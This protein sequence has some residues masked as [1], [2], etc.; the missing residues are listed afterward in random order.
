MLVRKTGMSFFLI[1]RQHS[2][3]AHGGCIGMPQKT[4][5]FKYC[6]DDPRIIEGIFCDHKI[7]FTQPWGMND[8]LEFNPTLQFPNNLAAH[9]GYSLNGIF[10][11]SIELFYRVQVIESQI[12]TYGILSLTTRHR[13]FDMWSR[14][15]NGHKG[16]VL[17][18]RQGFES[19]PCMMSKSDQ[20]NAFKAVEYVNTYSI[21]L[22]DFISGSKEFSWDVLHDEIFF[23]KTS[24][25]RD[26]HE[27]RLIRP[28]TDCSEYSPKSDRSHRDDS[29]Y[30]FDFSLECVTDVIFGASMSEQN[31]RKIVDYCRAGE[32][33]IH[34]WQAVIIR[35][36][37]DEH[38]QPSKIKTFPILD[39]LG[40]I[41]EI[42][43]I[44]PQQFSID[45][46]HELNDS[47]TIKINELK[48]LPYY[49]GHE[50]IIEQLYKE[51]SQR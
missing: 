44:Q 48:D 34:F 12:N 14:Y 37:K 33:D 41:E 3:I 19:H 13:S 50:D 26:E 36:A 7:R 18:F 23:K 16:F 35:D 22:D 40:S 28:L 1:H 15:A 51:A 32:S 21:N 45:S 31:K 29:V 47:I 11:P 4:M 20:K 5:L 8:P 24:R 42:Y 46:V 6:S 27:Y 49:K 2:K 9:Q 43:K 17:C 25:W 39:Y 38:K 30:L 10:L